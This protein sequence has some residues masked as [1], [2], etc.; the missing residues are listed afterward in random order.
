MVLFPDFTQN[1]STSL[2]TPPGIANKVWPSSVETISIVLVTS[3][4]KNCGRFF[5]ASFAH[6]NKLNLFRHSNR[7]V[8]VVH[9][10]ADHVNI[11]ANVIVL[12]VLRRM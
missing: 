10:G 7:W 8:L 1:I 6:Q 11:V 3:I 12:S 4:G 2:T 9:P 5:K